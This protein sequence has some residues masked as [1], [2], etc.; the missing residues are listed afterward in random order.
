MSPAH[1]GGPGSS[2]APRHHAL[3]GGGDAAETINQLSVQAA[4]PSQP[5]AAAASSTSSGCRRP[6][7]PRLHDNAQTIVVPGP[8]GLGVQ[9]ISSDGSRTDLISH[10]MTQPVSRARSGGRSAFRRPVAANQAA[11][12]QV[13]RLGGDG[14]PAISGNRMAPR[15]TCCVAPARSAKK[16]GNVPTRTSK[17]RWAV[18]ASAN[19]RQPAAR[20]GLRGHQPPSRSRPAPGPTKAVARRYPGPGAAADQFQTPAVPTN[21]TLGR[22]ARSVGFLL[23]S[24][25]HLAMSAVC[26]RPTVSSRRSYSA[27]TGLQR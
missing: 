19:Y 1:L 15:R 5:T 13:E 9:G 3:E 12:E 25:P 23:Y 2:T 17:A 26:T 21:V 27:Y 18:R 6:S 10:A 22:V 8:A 7:L 24:G 4:G 14:P 16:P 11:S 20:G